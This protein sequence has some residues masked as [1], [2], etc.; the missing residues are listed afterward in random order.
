MKPK[1]VEL[2][3]NHL[4]TTDLKF[5][6]S[7][8]PQSCNLGQ[9]LIVIHTRKKEG[10]FSYSHSPVPVWERASNGDTTHTFSSHYFCSDHKIYPLITIERAKSM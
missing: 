9:S 8:I 4:L 1:K 2:R 7:N 5:W 6:Y 10:I 3:T